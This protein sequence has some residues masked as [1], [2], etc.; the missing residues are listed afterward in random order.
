MVKQEEGFWDFNE[1]KY[2]V[3][4]KAKDN[5]DYKIY[6]PPKDIPKVN[7]KQELQIYNSIGQLV[8]DIIVTNESK[9]NVSNLVNGIYFA[10][11]KSNFNQTHKFIKQ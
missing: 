4:V 2:F 8:K 3:K 1:D 11:L 6:C 10:K 9:I 7:E 5:M